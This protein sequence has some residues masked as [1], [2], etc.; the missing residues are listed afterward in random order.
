MYPGMH[1]KAFKNQI[2]GSIPQEY[3]KL[4]FN[5]IFMFIS[6]FKNATNF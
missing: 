1:L 6:I 5:F 3:I 4:D 2:S